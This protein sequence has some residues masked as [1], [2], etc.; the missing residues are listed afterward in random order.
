MCKAALRRES[1]VGITTVYRWTAGIRVPTGARDFYLLTSVQ[2]GSVAHPAYLTGTRM[3][4]P[5][6]EEA[7]G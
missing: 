7:E 2:T 6:G 1:S 5:W 3:L 4:F